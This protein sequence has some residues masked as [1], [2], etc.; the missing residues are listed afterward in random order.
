VRRHRAAHAVAVLLLASALGSCAPHLVA[1]P[2]LDPQ[3]VADRY[4]VARAARAALAGALDA[5]AS[6]WL[7]GDS[8][9]DLPGVHARLA[10]GAPGAFRVRVESL[11]GVALDFAAWGESLA[12]FVPPRRLG[13][14]LDATLDTLGLRS[15]GPLGVHVLAATWEPPDPA[16]ALA[17]YE[18]SLLVVRWEEAGDSLAVGV[19]SDGMP[20]RAVRRDARGHTVEARYR[21]WEFIEGTSWPVRMEFE[22]RAAGIT[23]VLKLGHVVRNAG[24]APERLV[25]RIPPGA[26]RLEWPAIRRALART[27]GL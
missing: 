4:R 8:L 15:P 6:A 3:R 1:P 18:D 19:G 16:W 26:E 17:G 25:V 14:A 10:L 5:E 13:V 24:P 11:F 23:L 12:C 9:R 7:R 27:R 2:R 20:R 21:A 22:D